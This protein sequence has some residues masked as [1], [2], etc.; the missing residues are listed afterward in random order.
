MRQVFGLLAVTIVAM[1]PVAPS[2]AEAQVNPRDV[3][4]VTQ[5]QQRFDGGQDVQPIFEGWTRNEDGSYLFHFGYLN[6]N[7][8]EQPS[9]EVGPE[10]YFSPGGED[11]GQPTHFYPRTQRYQFTV[12]MPAD[13]GGSLEDGVAWRVTAHGS[14]QVAYG[15]LQPEW[16]IDPNTITSNSGTGFGRP[17][18]QIMENVAPVVELSASATNVTV[19]QAVTLTAMLKDD[20]LPVLLPPRK[21]RARLPSLV[22]PDD[23]P[24]TPDN[25]QWY[26]RP[27]PPRNG[28]SLLWTVYRGPAQ[29]DFEPSGYQ[30]SY[31]E[32]EAETEVDGAATAPT[33]SGNPATHTAGDG[34]TSATFETMVTFDEPGTYTVRGWASDAMLVT[35]SDLTITVQ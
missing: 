35:P 13:T 18:E 8:R 17:V 26:R 31:E 14:E 34:F 6:R 24:E 16:E 9:V 12:P 25:I 4:I 20:E 2:D 29:A 30:R 11:R 27:R 28:L 3:P 10:N 5:P 7:Y 32:Q 1:G 23:M 15:W 19:G 21:P 22:P 33:S